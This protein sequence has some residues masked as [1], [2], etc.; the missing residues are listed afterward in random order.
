[1]QTFI[2][3]PR[4]MGALPLEGTTQFRV[5]APNASAVSVVGEFNAWNPQA[6]PL[7]REDGGLWA[8]E[9]EGAKAGQ[10]YQFYLE[11]GEQKLTKNDPY[12]REI[13]GQ[14]AKGVIYNDNFEWKSPANVLPS[15][16]E[17]VMYEL[18][19]GTFSE[20]PRHSAGTFD[21]VI[22]RLPYLKNLGVNALELMPVMAFPSKT[23]WG[24]SLTN[25]FAVESSYGGPD[26]F[27][28]LIDAAHAEGIA[29]ILD[30][31]INHFGPDNLDL[32]QFDGWSENG[33]G[34][35]Y[36]YN[37]QRAWTPWGENRPDFGRG[38]VRQYLR[39]SCL[40]WLEEFHVD[41]LR[42]DA[43]LF[44]RNTRGENN[45]RESDIP[46]GWTL[47]QWI[48][49]EAKHFFPKTIL[50][51]EDLQQNGWVT[52]PT[53]DGGLGFDTQW[54]SAFIHPIR[55]SVVAVDDKDRSLKD[56]ARAILFR[57]NMDAIQRVIYSESHDSVANGQ[58]RI[59][60]EIDA[61]DTAGYY[62]R[63][64]SMLAA[65]L[66]LTT[67]GIP[68]L[69]EGQEFLEAGW[70]R[71]TVAIDWKKL[72]SF[73]KVN[74]LYRDLIHLRRNAF[75]NTKG[76][77]GPYAE[78]YHFN[79]RDKVLA[80]HRWMEHGPKDDV[81]VVASFTNQAFE[82]GY[83]LGLPSGGK[84]TVRFNSDWK[85]YGSDFDDVGLAE[86]V[87]TAEPEARD[88]YAFTGEVNLSSYGFL[89]LSQEEGDVW[90]I[91]KPT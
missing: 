19:V 44:I 2:H 5:W 52:K 32:W 71:D 48:N 17:L 43:T 51:A 75:G 46:E 67:P 53:R 6:D 73:K 61:G 30:I 50:I 87:I 9:V 88:G 27:K 25:P 24:Y 29:I 37:D 85:G 86:T 3:N 77:V 62:A 76:L 42:V 90:R 18:H 10:Q 15:W 78:I 79:D 1:M 33:K 89:I 70:F 34:G 7:T 74:R 8:R 23:S 38:E 84:W 45:K 14:T 49:D 36:F 63:K 82:S 28:R 47:M 57:Y 72:E 80:Y 55:G 16:N 81:I 59:P 31:V 40:L 66:T 69:F 58:A 21:Q 11:N 65:G 83:R 56:V 12:A 22:E 13:H 54:D 4:R 68:M 64:R 41:G 35:I 20:G 91:E 26:G 39:D 60:Q